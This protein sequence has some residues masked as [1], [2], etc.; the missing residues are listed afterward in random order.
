MA[1]ALFVLLLV[2]EVA[3]GHSLESFVYKCNTESIF[4]FVSVDLDKLTLVAEK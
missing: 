3:G 1:V 2:I 4:T